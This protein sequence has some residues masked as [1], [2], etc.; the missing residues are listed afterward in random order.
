MDEN[1]FIEIIKIHKKLLD[2]TLAKAMI[3]KVDSYSDG[4]RQSIANHIL[5]MAELLGIIDNYQEEKVR[6]YKEGEAEL[7]TIHEMSMHKIQKHIGQ[8]EEIIHT[9]EQKE[10]EKLLN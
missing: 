9:K 10:V 2:P 5:Y 6:I 7:K 4:Q 8:T 1:R 3:E